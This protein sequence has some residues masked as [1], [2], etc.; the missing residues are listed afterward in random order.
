[1]QVGGTEAVFPAFESVRL[2]VV[3]TMQLASP[4]I[5]VGMT[6]VRFEAPH[7]VL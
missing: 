6:T 5:T 4:L 3:A 1:M 7:G 2:V